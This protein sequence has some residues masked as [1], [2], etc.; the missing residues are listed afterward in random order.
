[1]AQWQSQNSW[2]SGSW[3]QSPDG[4]WSWHSSNAS[5]QN[6]QQQWESWDCSACGQTN[7]APKKKCSKCGIKKSY[8]LVTKPLNG[9]QQPSPQVNN[10]QAQ[11]ESVT[12]L[13]QQSLTPAA[14][15][16]DASVAPNVVAQSK[17][18]N[19]PGGVTTQ[20][21][22]ARLPAESRSLPSKAQLSTMI[23]S[24]ED[25]LARLPP[26][27]MFADQRAM[28]SAKIESLK[29]YITETK[30]IGARIDGARGFLA[31]AQTRREA[32]VTAMET[33]KLAMAAA[34]AEITQATADLA[35]LEA[36]LAN[37][38]VPEN[39]VD[40]LDVQLSHM[41]KLLSADGALPAE[42]LQSASNAAT[43]FL[44][45]IR[46]SFVAAQTN[47]GVTPQALPAKRLLHKQPPDPLVPGIHTRH[48][49]KQ[50]PK[51][52]L[53]DFFGAPKSVISKSGAK[54]PRQ[55][56]RLTDGAE[57]E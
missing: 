39:P 4:G 42:H 33:A 22:P 49:G 41:I 23:R 57:T 25:S 14:P 28:L 50:H 54:K 19:A 17:F 26:D 36:A 34:D 37:Q 35:E 24:A 21:P 15:V 44:Q 52:T 9:T 31:R 2:A 51:R 18:Q 1:M 43:Q 12:A 40:A 53:K 32:A 10:I 30:P 11:L 6:G 8:A 16:V 56:F 3:K 55:D 13:L 47:L 45:G 48:I 7:W 29:Q 38:H 5:Q 46:Q 20:F 27:E